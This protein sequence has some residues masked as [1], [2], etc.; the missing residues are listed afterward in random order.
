MIAKGQWK[1]WAMGDSKLG[2]KWHFVP[3]DTE[4]ALCGASVGEG[5]FT[6][7]RGGVT[8]RC[9]RCDRAI[10]RLLQEQP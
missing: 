1:T 2:G 6:H 3:L 9:R 8:R 10:D 5:A 4:R 7:A